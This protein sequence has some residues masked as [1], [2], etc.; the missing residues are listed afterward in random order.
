MACLLGAK[1]LWALSLSL[2]FCEAFMG[3]CLRGLLGTGSQLVGAMGRPSPSQQ[4]EFSEG[5]SCAEMEP[6][7]PGGRGPFCNSVGRGCRAT[8]RGCGLRLSWLG[9]GGVGL[10]S[11]F[12][13]F[14]LEPWGCCGAVGA[15]FDE[16]RGWSNGQDCP[17]AQNYSIS[18]IWNQTDWV[19]TLP[20][21]G[22]LSKFLKTPLCP[23]SFPHKGVII[24]LLPRSGQGLNDECT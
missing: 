16:G 21:P 2:T 5:R 18:G 15:R 10:A 12:S 24:C 1:G 6:A 3:P 23:T 4:E 8:R 7:V 9:G 11:H 14:P 20:R 19:P 17:F 22:T 13:C